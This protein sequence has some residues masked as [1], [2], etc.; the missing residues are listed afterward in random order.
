VG[1]VDL[2]LAALDPAAV[3]AHIFRVRRRVLRE[4]DF[5]YYL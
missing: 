3:P 5:A 2:D 1:W 4:Q